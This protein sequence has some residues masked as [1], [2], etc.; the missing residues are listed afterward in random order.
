MRSRV[1]TSVKEGIVKQ[2]GAGKA[3]VAHHIPHQQ[4]PAVI[5]GQGGEQGESPTPKNQAGHKQPLLWPLWSARE[6]STGASKPPPGTWPL[7]CHRTTVPGCRPSGGAH[8]AKV[9]GEQHRH[10]VGGVNGVGPVVEDPAL[11]PLL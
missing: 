5:I 7:R 9:D 3:N 2:A 10:D 4:A 8:I 11:F 1:V 6:P